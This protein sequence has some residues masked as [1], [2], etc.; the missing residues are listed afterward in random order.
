MACGF[1]S[2]QLQPCARA[3]VPTADVG[4]LRPLRLQTPLPSTSGESLSQN[5]CRF[6]NK[7]SAPGPSL[8]WKTGKGVTQTTNPGKGRV[9]PQRQPQHLRRD[10]GVFL[11]ARSPA[12]FLKG[13]SGF[14]QPWISLMR[15]SRRCIDWP[16]IA[17][18]C[19]CDIKEK[20]KKKGS[21]T[22]P[23]GPASPKV[24]LPVTRKQ[25]G[26]RR[27]RPGLRGSRGRSIVAASGGWFQ[28]P[29]LV[30]LRCAHGGWILCTVWC[31]AAPC[32][33]RMTPP[34][35]SVLCFLSP[36]FRRRGDG[37]P[38]VTMRNTAF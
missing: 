3:A 2:A 9:Q 17:S 6:R 22:T 25:A 14:T 27:G 34:A 11:E 16:F 18:A 19:S 23:A 29:T 35:K 7:Y 31:L 36:A 15:A 12:R 13:R 1:S 32:K 21:K 5:Y 38:D 37:I 20:E 24:A 8:V 28:E 33:Q 30:P 26:W 10:A 4:A